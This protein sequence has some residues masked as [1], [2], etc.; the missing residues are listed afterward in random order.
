MTRATLT[1]KPLLWPSF[2]S[3]HDLNRLVELH[4]PVL[5]VGRDKTETIILGAELTGTDYEFTH[6][7]S[8]SRRHALIETN[9]SGLFFLK[10]RSSMNGTVIKRRE[11]ITILV[12]GQSYALQN[13]DMIYFGGDINFN[14]ETKLDKSYG[15]AV[16]LLK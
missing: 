10:D 1:E 13:D 4:G 8:V 16:F 11:K 5:T 2:K 14:K 12:P 9:A 6:L 15:P 7:A 3:V